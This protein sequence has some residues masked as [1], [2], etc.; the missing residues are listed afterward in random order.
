M[1]G[2]GHEPNGGH[3]LPN[4]SRCCLSYRSRATTKDYHIHKIVDVISPSHSGGEQI[5][6]G[7][8]RC[9]STY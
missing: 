3:F 5:E 2:P 8:C 1:K 9:R 4:Q 7:A 6:L